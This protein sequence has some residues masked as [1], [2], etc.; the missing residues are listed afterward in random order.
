V[1]DEKA[2]VASAPRSTDSLTDSVR[3]VNSPVTAESMLK[4][5]TGNQ[6]PGGKLAIEVTC[7][8][9]TNQYH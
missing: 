4:A 6:Y 7:R 8:D 1:A 5:S 9:H 3:E 2:F